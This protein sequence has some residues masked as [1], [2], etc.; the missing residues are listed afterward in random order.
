MTMKHVDEIVRFE[1]QAAKAQP[2]LQRASDR[3]V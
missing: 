1:E 3:R 2:W